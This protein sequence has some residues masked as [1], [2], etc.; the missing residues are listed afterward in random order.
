MNTMLQEFATLH[1]TFRGKIQSSKSGFFSWKWVLNSGKKV[2][3]NIEKDL[4]VREERIK[5]Y[6][7]EESVRTLGVSM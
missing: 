7:N 6:N 1:E 3:Q 2:L 5:Q 4:R